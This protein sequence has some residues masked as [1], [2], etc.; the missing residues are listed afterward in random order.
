MEKDQGNFS[1]HEENYK[2][3]FRVEKIIFFLSFGEGGRRKKKK[4]NQW[5]R[6]A[7]Q[8]TMP[9]PV[10]KFFNDFTVAITLKF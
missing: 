10:G 8:K 9:M 6:E 3:M 1:K 5:N 7:A 4:H 2:K